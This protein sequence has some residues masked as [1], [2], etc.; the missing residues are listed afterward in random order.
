MAKS[1][2]SLP[3]PSRYIVHSD[4]FAEKNQTCKKEMRKTTESMNS[5]CQ[6]IWF[7]DV[8][9]FLQQERVKSEPKK[10]FV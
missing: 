8:L 4:I 1:S 3:L 9:V 2:H 7:A 10:L 6:D 5:K